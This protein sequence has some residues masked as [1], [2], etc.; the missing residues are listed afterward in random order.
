MPGGD[1]LGDHAAEA[2]AV[3]VRAPRARRPRA[4][5]TGLVGELRG[6][7]A[8]VQRQHPVALAEHGR[9]PQPGARGLAGPGDEEHGVHQNTGSSV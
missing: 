8:D 7:A 4:S 3:D 9:G 2:H 5:P 1:V 6:V